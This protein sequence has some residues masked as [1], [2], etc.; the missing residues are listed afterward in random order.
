MA[1]IDHPDIYRFGYFVLVDLFWGFQGVVTTGLFRVFRHHVDESRLGGPG[2]RPVLF[3]TVTFLSTQITIEKSETVI[4]SVQAL[5][6]L[7]GAEGLVALAGSDAQQTWLL[8][9]HSA[10]FNG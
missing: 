8:A 1:K 3:K 5:L 2:I 10:K 7:G 4:Y 9:S 6:E